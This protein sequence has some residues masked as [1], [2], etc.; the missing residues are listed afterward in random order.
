MAGFPAEV[1]WSFTS[2]T[3]LK[4]MCDGSGRKSRGISFLFHMNSLTH[5]DMP[6]RGTN[7]LTTTPLQP[8]KLSYGTQKWNERINELIHCSSKNRWFKLSPSWRYRSIQSSINQWTGNIYQWIVQSVSTT[9]VIDMNQSMGDFYLTRG[10]VILWWGRQVDIRRLL[11]SGNQ[12]E[13]RAPADA[14]DPG[15]PPA[16]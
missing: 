8:V 6:H 14:S 5:W 15:T 2:V 16:I 10:C 1:T 4:F 12:N 9:S 3:T 11:T 7:A 13:D